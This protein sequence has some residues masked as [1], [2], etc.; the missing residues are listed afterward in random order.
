MS[1][2]TAIVHNIITGA[3]NMI[4]NL[5][6][7]FVLLLSPFYIYIHI[8]KERERTLYIYIYIYIYDLCE[9]DFLSWG[10]TGHTN[11]ILNGN[12]YT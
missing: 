3:H 9:Y 5:L 6:L 11:I 12:I 4:I 8:Y 7:K 10:R 1:A 2:F